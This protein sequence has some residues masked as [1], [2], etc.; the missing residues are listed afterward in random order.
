VTA[1]N[2]TTAGRP[3]RASKVT[4]IDLGVR[5][6]HLLD[7]TTALKETGGTVPPLETS[8]LLLPQ[9]GASKTSPTE[10]D[11]IGSGTI[12]IVGEPGSGKSTLA[13]QIAVAAAKAGC[14]SAYISL[15]E[16]RERLIKKA[17]IFDWHSFLPP[18]NEDS[19]PFDFLQHLT[20]ANS[21]RPPACDGE[22]LRRILRLSRRHGGSRSQGRIILPTLSPRPLARDTS[23]LADFFWRQY[24]Q[25]EFLVR[26]AAEH[27]EKAINKGY[28]DSTG[29][30]LIVVDSLNM[31]GMEQNN[32][33]MLHRVFD[34]FRQHRI[35]GV[36]TIEANAP[37]GFDSTM[38][39]VV[40][41]FSR[42]DDSGYEITFIECTKSR[43]GC[44]TM[45]R[46]P[47]KIKAPPTARQIAKGILT[48]PE[49]GEYGIVVLPSPHAVV[50]AT[51]ESRPKAESS[52]GAED[53]KRETLLFPFGWGD[54]VTNHLLRSTLHRGHVVALAGPSGTFK[55]QVALNF[56]LHGLVGKSADETR[57][58]SHESV[59]YIRLGTPEE[60]D[61][62]G[63]LAF[64][65]PNV[66]DD[67]NVA[68]EGDLREQ[69]RKLRNKLRRVP[70]EKDNL[71]FLRAPNKVDLTVYEE[72]NYEGPGRP[73][74]FIQV[75]FRMGM[76]LA[77]EF[78]DIIERIRNVHPEIQRV[79][80]DDVGSIG[81]SY[82]LLKHST[83]TG[84]L[85]LSAF[86]HIIKN[87]GYDLL[88]V[89]TTG[90]FPEANHMV[91]RACT[92][93]DSVLRTKIGAVFGD[94]YVLLTGDGMTSKQPN[95][96]D[97][98]PVVLLPSGDKDNPMIK[99][100]AQLL[101]EFVGFD[102]GEIQRPGIVLHLYRESLTQERYNAEML[103][104]LQARYG[105][106]R[107]P[108]A[109]N[110]SGVRVQSFTPGRMSHLQEPL[111]RRADG[112]SQ[113]P[114]KALLLDPPR[115][116]TAIRMIDEFE[117]RTLEDD[118]QSKRDG[119]QGDD[120]GKE[121]V[122]MRNVLLVAYR[123][124]F[125]GI[126]QCK[127]WQAMR[128]VVER[129]PHR[130]RRFAFDRKAPETLAC[131]VLDAIAS[132]G[133][134]KWSNSRGQFDFAE[135]FGVHSTQSIVQEFD[136]LYELMFRHSW[137]EDDQ[138]RLLAE[139][140]K[141]PSQASPEARPKETPFDPWTE[142]LPADA[143]VY[144]CWYS[145]LREL[146]DREPSLTQELTVCNLPAGGFKGDWYLRVEP[147]SVSLNLG[148]SIVD[149]L[150]SPAEDYERF[151]QG[152][153]LPVTKAIRESEVLVWHGAPS[154]MRLKTFV[155]PIW[156][157]AH[158]RSDIYNYRRFNRLLY[159]FGETLA[160]KRVDRKA[161]SPGAG[162]ERLVDTTDLVER[163]PGLVKALC[164]S[165][166]HRERREY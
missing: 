127:S 81:V 102:S 154:T 33:E 133:G 70:R 99:P 140:Y 144:V 86:V 64:A 9:L 4:H 131:L 76:L 136:A 54:A 135:F 161:I 88:L 6:N 153:C 118:V 156:T 30:R 80:V 121:Q 124:E 8:G 5:L 160:G 162:S 67:C 83:T 75:D 79:V 116:H 3:L 38:G 14:D 31:L 103:K 130:G 109:G 97:T 128:D 125:E 159:T 129:L 36:F 108:A 115:D 104:R 63:V 94:R 57:D 122:L 66:L 56:L 23:R 35:M 49:P 42:E 24:E 152:L 85:F 47:Y 123:K 148:K 16:E 48:D 142:S 71:G 134:W 45:G 55:T 20:A 138:K 113:A 13:L 95:Q 2:P 11:T 126:F 92:L 119:S 7:R 37:I 39:D 28:R 25:I 68:A 21:G 65:D 101:D 19:R 132:G 120:D 117:L 90:D 73:P 155:E 72:E 147:G 87:H 77:E 112:S 150:T 93:A 17:K 151:R 12:V 149:R 59:L 137:T 163:L 110:T 82:P 26:S 22:L 78:I 18:D 91:H 74:K 60:L 69:V 157:N 139:S 106:W 29:I 158:R 32:R 84:D 52:N 105:V 111:E 165:N 34:L 46:H 96:G 27:N 41:T 10:I 43:F 62:K 100:D 89:G 1:H 145:Q 58:E 50:H 164:E 61:F 166:E 114:D 44:R 143:A 15:E 98:P 107:T 141:G 40:F 51:S 53:Q 146:L